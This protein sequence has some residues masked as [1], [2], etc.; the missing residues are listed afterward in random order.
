MVIRVPPL[1]NPKREK[2]LASKHHRPQDSSVTRLLCILVLLLT[3]ACGEDE[4]ITT[5]DR[6]EPE[7]PAR[8]PGESRTDNFLYDSEGNLR[9]SEDIVAGLTLPRG[10]EV[11]R[12]N[13]RRHI[14]RSTVPRAKL[15]AYFGPRLFTGA[16]DPI[17]DG[18]VF[19]GATV[20]GAVGSTVRLDVS[21]LQTG[22]TSRIEIYELPPIPEN[23]PSPAELQRLWDEEQRRAE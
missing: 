18:A 4:V 15:L 9:E 16:V 17:G 10:L 20:Q 3:G 12:E 6:V 5:P 2:F 11:D 19:R 1:R 13:E 14:Y 22:A 8:P 21:I 7:A 23:P